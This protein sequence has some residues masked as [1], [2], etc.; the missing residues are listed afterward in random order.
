MPPEDETASIRNHHVLAIESARDA[1]SV[2]VLCR[3]GSAASST[4]LRPRS[5]AE[6][7][8]PMAMQ[9]VDRVGLRFNEIDVVAV[10]AGPGS[11]TGLRI[12]VSAAKGFAMAHGG[13]LVGVSTLLAYARTVA[14]SSRLYGRLPDRI[15]IALSARKT[16]LYFAVFETRKESGQLRP[17]VKPAVL[18]VAEAAD[19][20]AAIP[21]DQ[22]VLVAGDGAQ[23]LI[24]RLGTLDQVRKWSFIPTA[25]SIAEIAVE[26]ARA[27]HFDDVRSFEPHYL[28]DYVAGNS[29]SVF[30]RLT[31]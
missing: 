26:R 20:I 25:L 27:G 23:D 18:D 28:K 29:K 14:H 30:E 19:D 6:R 24:D 5:H 4:T 1:C 2:A 21:S 8:V 13:R 7:L 22:L 3:D 10:S 12:G 17:L 15:A 9:V 16:E 11:Y 31:L